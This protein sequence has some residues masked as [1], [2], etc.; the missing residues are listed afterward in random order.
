MYR[1]G[2]YW[3]GTSRYLLGAPYALSGTDLAYGARSDPSQW[4]QSQ[5]QEAAQVMCIDA[6]YGGDAAVSACLFCNVLD[7]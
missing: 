1:I 2:Q 5:Q 4:L 3:P 6:I 7:A